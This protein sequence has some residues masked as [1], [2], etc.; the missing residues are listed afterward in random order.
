MNL[1]SPLLTL[2]AQSRAWIHDD[3]MSSTQLFMKVASLRWKAPIVHRG[4]EACTYTLVPVI[5]LGLPDRVLVC[6]VAPERDSEWASS[7]PR[8]ISQPKRDI[9]SNRAAD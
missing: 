9:Q 5:G 6:R 3:D 2:L 1:E 4:G 8:R 7:Q